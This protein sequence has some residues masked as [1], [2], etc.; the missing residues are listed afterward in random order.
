MG[1]AV[2]VPDGVAVGVAVGAAVGPT[3][4]DALGIAPRIITMNTGGSS[5]IQYLRLAAL[6]TLVGNNNN[7][8]AFGCSEAITEAIIQL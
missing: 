6:R 7:N 1:G 2:G 5:I 8:Y 4:G 3:L